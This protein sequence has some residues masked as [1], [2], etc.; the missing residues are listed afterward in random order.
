MFTYRTRNSENNTLWGIL[1]RTP[2]YT[3]LGI[4]CTDHTTWAKESCGT[5]YKDHITRP[6]Y[7]QNVKIAADIS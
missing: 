2:Q 7:R 4:L 5:C 3:L 1:D 6:I